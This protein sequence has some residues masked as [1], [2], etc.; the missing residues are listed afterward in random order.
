MKLKRD[1]IIKFDLKCDRRKHGDFYRVFIFPSPA[2][3]KIFWREFCRIMRDRKGNKVSW[4]RPSSKFWAQA[5]WWDAIDKKGKR[6]RQRGMVLFSR[7][8][9]G[10]GVVSHEMTHA[11]LY[12][13]V[14]DCK[15]NPLKLRK[16]DDEKLAWTQGYLV[17]QFWQ[18]YYRRFHPFAV[19]ARRNKRRV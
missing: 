9:V 8:S 15:I 13:V 5:S 4:C 16:Q 18:K 6:D 19:Y 11:A 17:Q 1:T 3:M 7:A 2:S 10:G 12:W 14:N